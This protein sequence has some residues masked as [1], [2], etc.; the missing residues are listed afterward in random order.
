MYQAEEEKKI[1]LY[2]VASLCKRKM[3]ERRLD[4]FRMQEVISKVLGKPVE[5]NTGKDAAK[6]TPSV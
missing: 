1:C 3:A 2:H 6:K 5:L 4:S